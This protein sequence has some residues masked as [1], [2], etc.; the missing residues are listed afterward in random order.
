[1]NIVTRDTQKKTLE[2]FLYISC[3]VQFGVQQQIIIQT[4]DITWV[5]AIEVLF[6]MDVKLEYHT[7]STWRKY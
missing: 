2:K 3:M 1:M 5:L 7:N 4:N 6:L